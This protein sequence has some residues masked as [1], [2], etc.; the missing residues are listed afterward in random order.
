[1]SLYGLLWNSSEPNPITEVF[2]FNINSSCTQWRVQFKNAEENAMNSVQVMR[3]HIFLNNTVP[4]RSI[5]IP[6]TRGK[7]D[8]QAKLSVS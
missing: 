4:V 6:Y 2:F 5:L 1:M 3:G 8:D 7:M